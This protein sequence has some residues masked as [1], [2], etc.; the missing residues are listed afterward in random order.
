VDTVE[1][2]QHTTHKQRFQVAQ[3]GITIASKHH[4]GAKHPSDNKEG[5][6]EVVAVRSGS[7]KDRELNDDVNLIFWFFLAF[8]ELPVD[9]AFVP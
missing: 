3:L 9:S 6:A 8:L 2:Y 5:G 7:E 1:I 4:D